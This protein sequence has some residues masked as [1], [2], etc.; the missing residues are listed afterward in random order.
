[1]REHLTW[2]SR[3][4]N[5]KCTRK[6]R[7]VGQE[8]VRSFGMMVKVAVTRKVRP[9][10]TLDLALYVCLGSCL[11]HESVYLKAFS[12]QQ[13]CYEFGFFLRPAQIR[14]TS[15]Q[16]VA[17]HQRMPH[18]GGCNMHLVGLV[19]ALRVEEAPCRHVLGLLDIRWLTHEHPTIDTARREA[20]RV[21]V[22]APQRV[23]RRS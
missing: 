23:R 2:K 6:K 17:H 18:L 16:R 15:G 10:G 13:L 4:Q 19:L 8:D 14:C 3:I 20:E 11:P 7:K 12:A 9:L 1:M 21:S 5:K 22:D